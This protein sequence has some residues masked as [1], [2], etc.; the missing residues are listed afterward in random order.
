MS[1]RPHVKYCTVAWSPHYIKDKQL[2]EKIQRRVIK[3]IPGFRDKSYEDGLRILRL[4]TLEERWNWE[5]Y[6]SSSRCTRGF[7]VL[8]LRHSFSWRSTTKLEVMCWS[9]PNIA[10]TEMSGYIFSL[11]GWSTTGTIWTNL[12][13]RLAVLIRLNNVYNHIG[14]TIWTYSWTDVHKVLGRIWSFLRVRPCQVNYQVN[15]TSD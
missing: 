5:I 3:M 10:L 2:I 1:H 7:L 15:N 8:H 12:S 11:K 13:L 6:S 9:S 4:D 14:T